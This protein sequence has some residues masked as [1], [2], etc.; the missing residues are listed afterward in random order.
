MPELTSRTELAG[1]ARVLLIA[2]LIIVVDVR[3]P[4]FDIVP[5]AVGG[6]L[7]LYAMLRLRSVV[8][9]ADGT[10][11]VL[12][13]LAVIAAAAAVLE[14]LAP[15]IGPLALLPLSQPLGAYVLAGLMAR[16]LAERELDLAGR[17]RMAER[18]ILWLG[19]VVAMVGVLVTLAAVNIQIETPFVLLLV[20]ILAIPLGALLVALWRTAGAPVPQDQPTPVQDAA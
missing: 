18:L 8:R 12:V 20:V 16:L 5:D 10:L 11:R 2:T 19:V 1:L 6:A 3:V 7:V 13:V 14:T 9:G 15:L 17:W 4:I